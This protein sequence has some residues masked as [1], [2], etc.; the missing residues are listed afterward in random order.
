MAKQI[1]IRIPDDQL[2]ALDRAIEAGSLESRADGVRKGLTRLLAELREERIAREYR[3]A[4]TRQPDDPAVGE[5]GA[6]L[7]AEAFKREGEGRR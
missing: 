6:I 3:E 5:A 7:L 4:Y 2:E 1:A